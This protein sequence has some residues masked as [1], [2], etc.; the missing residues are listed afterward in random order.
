MNKKILLAASLLSVSSAAVAGTVNFDI[1]AD[2][3]STT[4]DKGNSDFTKFYFKTGRL[5]YQGKVNDN[6]SF[7][8]RLAFNKSAAQGASDSVDSV[9]SATEYAYLANKVTDYL[10]I[11]AGK[12]NT[13]VGGFEGVTPSSDLYLTSEA[14]TNKNAKG[15][16]LNSSLFS[17]SDVLYA[18]GVKATFSGAGQTVQVLAVNEAPS[19]SKV[20]TIATQNSS[21]MGITWRGAFLEKALN[22]IASYHAMEGITHDDKYQF[23]AAGVLWNES[24]FTAQVDYLNYDFKGATKSE[25]DTTSSF[26][27]KFSYTG[28][29]QWTPRLEI[30]TSD[31]KDNTGATTK[32][33]GVGAVVEY[34]PYADTNFRYHAAYSNI[35]QEPKIGDAST[36]Q[37]VVVGVRLMADFLK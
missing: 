15:S 1:R 25:K 32:Y 33:T 21:M 28:F 37:E 31:V 34:K 3:N 17:T 36:K 13:E 29:E 16:T 10:T 7:R 8:A 24:P 9:A 12:M 30:S 4:Y 6:L 5:D 19:D 26:I 27:G 11:T 20:G 22:F 23:M 18:T 35:R 2:Y 14:Y